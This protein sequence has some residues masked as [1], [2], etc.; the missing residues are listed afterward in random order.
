MSKKDQ[1]YKIVL[2][3]ILSGRSIEDITYDIALYKLTKEFDQE[4]YEE[5]VKVIT[6]VKE[7]M[8]NHGGL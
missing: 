4:L 1:A 2:F 6:E 3:S 8:V 7:W 5:L